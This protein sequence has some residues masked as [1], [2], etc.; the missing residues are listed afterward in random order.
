LLLVYTLR[1]VPSE[2][3]EGRYAAFSLGNT[4]QTCVLALMLISLIRNEPYIMLMAQWAAIYW[5]TTVTLLLMFVP[6]MHNVHWLRE[7][8]GDLKAAS[9]ML[10]EA[11]MTTNKR[12]SNKRSSWSA[13]IKSAKSAL[14][15][16]RGTIQPRSSMDQANLITFRGSGWDGSRR[17]SDM[18][19]PS[20]RKPKAAT[21]PSSDDQGQGAP[22]PSSDDQGQ[23]AAAPLSDDQGHGACGLSLNTNAGGSQVQFGLSGATDNGAAADGTEMP[24]EGEEDHTSSESRPRCES[25]RL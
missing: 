22:A 20:P 17:G 15:G 10:K 12:S 1:N 7:G 19:S 4:A 11:R 13:V 24:G 8:D 14:Q 3:N 6:K 5:G 16:K 21:A 2:F 9:D 25:T 18:P 23:G